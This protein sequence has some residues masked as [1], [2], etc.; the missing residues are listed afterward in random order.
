MTKTTPIDGEPKA[1]KGTNHTNTKQR[2]TRSAKLPILRKK[3]PQLLWE[4]QTQ[5]AAVEMKRLAFH[6][7]MRQNRHPDYQHLT[8]SNTLS[9]AEF[10]EPPP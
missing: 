9:V 4:E 10:S 3:T 1:T 6:K 2:V 7:T 8:S 5:D